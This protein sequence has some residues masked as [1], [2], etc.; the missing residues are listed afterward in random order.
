MPVQPAFVTV[1]AVANH[2]AQ[3]V[4]Q[5][6]VVVGVLVQDVRAQAQVAA[7][8]LPVRRRVVTASPADVPAPMQGHATAQVPSAAAPA[9]RALQAIARITEAVRALP[10][11]RAQAAARDHPAPIVRVVPPFFPSNWTNNRLARPACKIC[12]HEYSI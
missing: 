1:N 11:V 3:R 6:R 12:H 10:L 7:V 4:R 9:H 5:V 2:N 8:R